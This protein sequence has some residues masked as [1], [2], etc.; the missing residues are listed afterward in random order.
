MRQIPLPLPRTWGGKR[1]RAGRKPKHGRAGVPHV[2]RPVQSRHHPLH[3]TVRVRPGLPSLRSQALFFC[4][5]QQIGT[6]SRRFLR[7][8]HFSMQS[9][10]IHM[11]VET[12]DRS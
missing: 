5:R 4:V 3:V 8:V 6:A 9:N 2:R 12:N 7:I 10:H 1:A 11:I